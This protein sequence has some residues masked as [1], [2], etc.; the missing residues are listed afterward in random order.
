MAK[1]AE[2]NIHVEFRTSDGMFTVIVDKKITASKLPNL[3]RGSFRAQKRPDEIRAQ[4]L[5][6]EA[7][8][9]ILLME[10][11]TRKLH[12]NQEVLRI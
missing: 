6:G 3:S 7:H 2:S 9:N 8:R 10:L 5:A 12:R 11:R 4:V 1:E